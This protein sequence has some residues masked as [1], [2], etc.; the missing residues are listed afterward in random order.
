MRPR[1]LSYASP[2]RG[3]WGVRVATVLLSWSSSF[4]FLARQ[5]PPPGAL[6]EELEHLQG[7]ITGDEDWSTAIG[8][9]LQGENEREDQ[10]LALLE[11]AVVG[12][13]AGTG[14]SESSKHQRHR[15]HHKKG[16][17]VA[18][19]REASSTSATK[20]VVGKRKQHQRK[21]DASST[22]LSQKKNT[23]DESAVAQELA[24]KREERKAHIARIRERHGFETKDEVD[25]P[26]VTSAERKKVES[27]SREDSEERAPSEAINVVSSSSEEEAPVSLVAT[28]RRK[29]S[30]KSTRGHS[31]A[32]RNEEEQEHHGKGARHHDEEHESLDHL[33]REH[34]QLQHRHRA[35]EE[36]EDEVRGHH[37]KYDTED[38]PA[39]AII[40][41][42]R[43]SRFLGEEQGRHAQD[44]HVAHSSAEP[45]HEVRRT[46]ESSRWHRRAAPQD[47]EDEEVIPMSEST[48]RKSAS[49]Q[50]V[51]ELHPRSAS[52]VVLTPSVGTVGHPATSAIESAESMFEA[53]PDL[54]SFTSLSELPRHEIHLSDEA[55]RLAQ[56]E[57]RKE[58]EEEDR[59]E[60]MKQDQPLHQQEIPN[61]RRR[62]NFYHHDNDDEE[63]LEDRAVFDE[64]RSTSQRAR[65]AASSRRGHDQEDDEVEEHVVSSSMSSELGAARLASPS[66]L[67]SGVHDMPLGLVE[68]EQHIR[69]VVADKPGKEGSRQA[70]AVSK[71]QVGTKAHVLGTSVTIGAVPGT[72]RKT[73]VIDAGH[74]RTSEQEGTK[75]SEAE[76]PSLVVESHAEKSVSTADADNK[77]TKEK[78]AIS[79][80]SAE[81]G[82]DASVGGKSSKVEKQANKIEDKKVSK[83]EEGQQAEQQS[84]K[85]QQAQLAGQGHKQ[86]PPVPKTQVR[87][88]GLL[89][90]VN[91]ATGM[92][93]MYPLRKARYTP[94]GEKPD[95][96]ALALREG[97]FD[98]IGEKKAK[99]EVK[100][101]FAQAQLVANKR[102]QERLAREAARK[103]AAEKARLAKRKV[104]VPQQAV[105]DEAPAYVPGLSPEDENSGVWR[106]HHS[107]IYHSKNPNSGYLMGSPLAYLENNEIS[108]SMQCI[109]HMLFVFCLISACANGLGFYER[110]FSSRALA[111]EKTEEEEKAAEGSDAHKSED[112]AESL[113]DRK[114]S[115]S[116]AAL[117]TIQAARQVLGLMPML[118]VMFLG[119]TMRA[120]Q[121]SLGSPGK[122]GLP[123]PYVET[124]MFVA[125]WAV[126]GKLGLTFLIPILTGKLPD[127]DAEGNLLLGTDDTRTKTAGVRMLLLMRAL[128]MIVTFCCSLAISYG[129]YHMADYQAVETLWKPHDPPLMSSAVAS[130]QWLTDLTFVIYLLQHL[131]KLANM[132]NVDAIAQVAVQALQ[133][134]PV[135]A[136]LFLCARSRALQLNP[137][138]GEPQ[139]WCQKLFYLCVAMMWLQMISILAVALFLVDTGDGKFKVKRPGIFAFFNALRFLCLTLLYAGIIGICFGISQL[140]PPESEELFVDDVAPEMSNTLVTILLLLFEYFVIHLVQYMLT[141]YRQV[142]D[143]Q[144]TEIA[145][146]NK[147]VEAAKAS[148]TY[149]PILV[150]FFFAVMLRARQMTM[151]ITDD[152]PNNGRLGIPVVSCMWITSLAV[153]VQIFAAFL[154][155]LLQNSESSPRRGKGVAV[156]DVF[157]GGMTA[158]MFL[159]LL[160][161]VIALFDP[162]ISPRFATV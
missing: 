67:A 130:V 98:L 134:A 126:T 157:Q 59:Q 15:R 39:R 14:R 148:V 90:D 88:I 38:E 139:K 32:A 141:V 121:L 34:D 64:T 13:T 63:L 41:D 52:K 22:S 83:T 71:Q 91:N 1:R 150:V 16:E 89:V 117:I 47:E 44:E 20:E 144:V 116:G 73:S 97:V 65:R 153:T 23:V 92:P 75:T 102:K 2:G 119:T 158:V 107:T 35:H 109:I 161:C 159:G 54:M 125:V 127:V 43:S 55:L 133:V 45:M 31:T 30:A 10:H 155:P 111:L 18:T 156:L 84:S 9:D 138:T 99:A 152:Y 68:T 50:E 7:M 77:K 8:D 36:H 113:L 78:R 28:D 100:A 149:V 29:T 21:T 118:G 51:Q 33:D 112:D 76:H 27:H 129:T 142:L 162:D 122:I 105:K 135:L 87:R 61:R 146:I 131:C 128:C 124:S 5:V 114:V 104:L 57:Q 95:D 108:T 40:M 145:Q 24:R 106:P 82:L 137:K 80:S 6:D 154:A 26:P 115:Y 70:A 60:T 53:N 86:D 17:V 3:P 151:N 19:S 37:M 81:E 25:R 96:L 42:R 120:V 4:S 12:T 93:S 110:A 136:I 66:K 103:A 11:T 147:A 85:I 62:T 72:P 48:S 123:Q 101:R 79:S 132:K 58:Q 74:A 49:R 160:P 69:S 143:V 140:T 46:R 94:P 56:E